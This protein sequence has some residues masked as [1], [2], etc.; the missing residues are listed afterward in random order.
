MLT[1]R[2][3]LSYV[4]ALAIIAFLALVNAKY[5]SFM[6]ADHKAV[7]VSISDNARQR[8]RVQR[9]NSLVSSRALGVVSHDNE[10]TLTIAALSADHKR[11]KQAIHLSELDE[12]ATKDL[13]QLYLKPPNKL[14]HAVEDYIAR[15]KAAADLEIGSPQLSDAAIEL[16]SAS[17]SLVPKFELAMSAFQ[18]A[19]DRQVGRMERFDVV[20]TLIVLITLTAEALFIFQPLI[21]RINASFDGVFQNAAV[22]VASASLDG[23]LLN[24]NNKLCAI[25]GLARTEL[26]NKSIAS[27]AASNLA[28]TARRRSTSGNL[29]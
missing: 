5:Q 1:R 21:R 2:L 12:A 8:L 22:G 27:S 16:F 23:R 3:E 29:A 24:F 11:L 20:F 28:S 10:L 9:I 18:R 13:D 26:D 19:G 6:L 7:V 15:A 25:C 17:R 4:L 14:D